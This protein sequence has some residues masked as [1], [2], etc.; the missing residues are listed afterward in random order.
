M[1][2]RR[3]RIHFVV[4]F[5]RVV[6]AEIGDVRRIADELRTMPNIALSSAEDVRCAWNYIEPEGGDDD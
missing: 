1:A 4:S 2:T 6:E 5:D 3:Y